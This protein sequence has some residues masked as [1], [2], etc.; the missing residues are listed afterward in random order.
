MKLSTYL[1]FIG[2]VGAAAVLVSAPVLGATVGAKEGGV[3]GGVGGFIIGAV[4]GAIVAP[5]MLIG[6]AL[7]GVGSV[8]V[9][10]FNTPAAISAKAQGKVWDEDKKDWIIYD[11]EK[12]KAEYLDLSEEDYIKQIVDDFTSKNKLNPGAAPAA[13]ASNAPPAGTVLKTVAD[14]EFYDVLGVPT[15]ATTAQI[16]KAYY[17]KARE[18]HPDRNT[19]DPNAH[20]RFQ[21]IGEAYQVL[22]DDQLRA[23]YDKGGKDGV[24]GVP[25]MDSSALF[26][27]LFGSEK[28]D[29][30]LGEL[31][32]AS[33]MQAQ[34]NADESK[35]M[36][37]VTNH[38]RLLALRQKKRE[39][40]C[41]VK[42]IELLK[43][44]VDSK[45]ANAE[46]F[47]VAIKLEAQELATTPFGA[48][49]VHAI[50]V[51][52][53]EYAATESNS[54][55]N[56]TIGMQQTGRNIGTKY[57]IA[58]KSIG[59]A[60]AAQKASK[61]KE[62]GLK[63]RTELTQTTEAKVHNAMEEA[64]MNIFQVM[65]NVTELDIRST[66]LHVCSRVTHDHS[67]DKD[68]RALRLQGIK[69][70]G[71]VFVECGGTTEA[72][73]QDVKSRMG[74]AAGRAQPA[75]NGPIPEETPA[76]TAAETQQPTQTAAPAAAPTKN[77]LSDSSA[78]LD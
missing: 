59:A 60:V 19:G 63:N 41:A 61:L 4:G 13:T 16:K 37:D 10:L 54:V 42:L 46:T 48:T 38:P 53:F 11:L 3:V 58:S 52:Y 40:K 30:Y 2:A 72:G 57:N 31:Q 17:V 33:Q 56:L 78:G 14:K 25:K 71:E 47:K 55:D 6:S 29:S 5:C 67:V 28:F 43:T 45:G 21:K 26:T 65:W 27:M 51:S 7:S 18:S 62:A 64:Q 24:E 23:N 44:Y 76:Q 8:G 68:V 39:I 34:S 49:L 74:M 35:G 22:S 15:D 73:L 50:G 77:P 32:L 9:G 20:A 70:I 12:E 36:F 69:L 66:L 1:V 75:S